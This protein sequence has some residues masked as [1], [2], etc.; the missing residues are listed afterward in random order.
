M[1]STEKVRRSKRRK[2]VIWAVIT[3]VL[4]LYISFLLAYFYEQWKTECIRQLSVWLA[5]YE[6]IIILQ[7]VRSILLLQVWKRSRD[8]AMIQVTVDCIWSI[9]FLAEIGW[10]VYGNTFIYSES[11]Q[12]CR[13]EDADIDANA[14]WIST[15]V[16]ICWGYCLIL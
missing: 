14:L 6:G 4:F 5:V 10:S 15:L 9:V 11:S 16:L 3:C 12:E 8:P 13:N 2:L 1:I 7:L